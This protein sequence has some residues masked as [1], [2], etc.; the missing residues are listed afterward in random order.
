MDYSFSRVKLTK[1]FNLQSESSKS[2]LKIYYD[3]KINSSEIMI[4][5]II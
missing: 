5:I 4:M 3:F 2:I 1:V